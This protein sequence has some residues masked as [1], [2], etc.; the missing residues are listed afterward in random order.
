MYNFQVMVINLSH[1][2]VNYFIKKMFAML[3]NWVSEF[4]IILIIS[5]HVFKIHRFVS[6]VLKK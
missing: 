6:G 5:K 3:K 4:H 2:T 1:N